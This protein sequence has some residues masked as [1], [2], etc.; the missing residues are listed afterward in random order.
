MAS[1]LIFVIFTIIYLV[2]RSQMVNT[3][4]NKVN[5]KGPSTWRL[6]TMC[7][8]IAIVLYQIKSNI[9]ATSA[10]CGVPQWSNII[11]WTV[12]PNVIFFGSIFLIFEN[13]PGWKGP[14]ANTFGYAWTKLIRIKGFTLKSLLNKI[15]RNELTDNGDKADIPKKDLG[16]GNNSTGVSDPR[17]VPGAMDHLH[18]GNSNNVVAA[19]K[20]KPVMQSGGGVSEENQ[21]LAKLLVNLYKDPTDLIN[22]ISPNNW[23]KWFKESPLEEIFKPQYRKGI[24]SAN[25]LPEIKDLYSFVVQRDLAAE[26]IWLVLIGVFINGLQTN[27]LANLVCKTSGPISTSLPTPAEQDDN[28]KVGTKKIYYTTE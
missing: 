4:A 7:Y 11:I 13:F 24:D 9:S 10:I 14:F 17:D 18:A 22:E 5:K 3:W 20:S 23:D 27:S 8:V 2:L 16:S 6:L 12:I 25:P 19:A 15:L 1:F 26:C 21:E 28:T